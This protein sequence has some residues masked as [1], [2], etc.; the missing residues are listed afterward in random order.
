GMDWLV[1]FKSYPQTYWDFL[2][3]SLGIAWTLA[4]EL[5]FY[6]MAPWLLRS[7]RVAIALFALSVALRIGALWLVEG[8]LYVIWSYFFFP[9]TL[10]FFLLGH[11]ARQFGTRYSIGLMGS[12]ALL[13]M[14]AILSCLGY[15][16]VSVDFPA[17]YG[18]AVCFALALPGLFRA[19]KD[20]RFLNFCGDLTYP[21]YL[22]HSLV[23]VVVF[24]PFAAAP[25]I[26]W[27][28]ASSAPSLVLFLGFV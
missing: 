20:N 21:L 8:R 24:W 16:R 22:T 25:L 19:T 5:T 1:A 12:L 15:A 17:E 3:S 23:V 6:A 11:F 14:A 28:K 7:A 4:A 13:A 27:A 10:M 18:A 2:P 26:A 9:A